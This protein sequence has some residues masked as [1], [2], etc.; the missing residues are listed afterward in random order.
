MKF[1]Y[2][3]WKSTS[4]LTCHFEFFSD[5]QHFSHFILF[6]WCVTIN[7]INSWSRKHLFF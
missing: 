1:H 7:I 3:I 6:V 5:V 2:N 4:L